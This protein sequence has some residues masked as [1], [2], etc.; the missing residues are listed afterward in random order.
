MTTSPYEALPRLPG[1]RIPVY[2][3]AGVDSHARRLAGQFEHAHTYLQNLFALPLDVRL[4]LLSRQDWPRFT[5]IPSYGAAWY[6]YPQRT[7]VCGAEPTTFWRPLVTRL[8]TAAPD[9]FERL[10]AAYA[11]PEGTL[12]LVPHTNLWMIHDLGHACHLRDGYWFPRK[13]LMELFAHLCLYTY[14][15][16]QASEDETRAVCFFS[17]LHALPTSF[18]TYRH[19][20]DF[21]TQYVGLPLDD[22]LWFSGHLMHLAHDLYAQFGQ[23]ALVRLWHL[24]VRAKQAD[25]PDTALWQQT[26]Q[27]DP[28][29]TTV[30]MAFSEQYA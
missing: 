19:L 8:Q 7:V 17:V 18:V 15:R 1:C 28:A 25:L 14:I 12:D 24:F 11:T 10:H 22:Y 16:E 30:L 3:S 9:L 4:A 2:V 26:M 21:E 20:T 23:A 13:W 6:D 29:L 27:A 5:H